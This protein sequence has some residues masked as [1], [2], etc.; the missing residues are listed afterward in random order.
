MDPHPHPAYVEERRETPLTV[1]TEEKCRRRPNPPNPPP[2]PLRPESPKVG[3]RVPVCRS[4]FSV[5][6]LGSTS[7]KV[8]VLGPVGWSDTGPQPRSTFDTYRVCRVEGGGS[9]RD[10]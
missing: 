4:I 2:L 6:T 9:T 1:V 5:L 8:L 3:G 7:L 10:L